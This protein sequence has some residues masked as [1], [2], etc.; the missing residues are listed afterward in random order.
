[1]PCRRIGHAIIR[2]HPYRRTDD[3]VDC[4]NLFLMSLGLM[5]L[6]PRGDDPF[7]HASLRNVSLLLAGNPVSL[8]D[9]R[10][11]TSNCVQKIL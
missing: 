7:A 9:V 5:A 4:A 8:T 1:M 2:F 3:L 11:L 10:E 6:K